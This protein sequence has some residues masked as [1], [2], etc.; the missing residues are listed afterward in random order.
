MATL[1]TTKKYTLKEL[2]LILKNN[3]DLYDLF[4]SKY[5]PEVYNMGKDSY[6]VGNLEEYENGMIM[7]RRFIFIA[8]NGNYK[9]NYYSK[10]LPDGYIARLSAPRTTNSTSIIGGTYLTLDYVIDINDIQLEENIV[11]YTDI[12]DG[13]I[14]STPKTFKFKS[15]DLAPLQDIEI[16]ERLLSIEKN[17]DDLYNELFIDVE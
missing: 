4:E 2:Q 3:T 7:I 11:Y 13:N 8:K 5:I 10:I 17:K 6:L 16:F 9:Y 14:V 1:K 12:Q 15:I